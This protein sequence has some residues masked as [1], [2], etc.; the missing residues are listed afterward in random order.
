VHYYSVH[1]R[2]PTSAGS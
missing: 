2:H 1:V